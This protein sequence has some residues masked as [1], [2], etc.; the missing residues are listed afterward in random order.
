MRVLPLILGLIFIASCSQSTGQPSFLFRPAPKPGIA[1]KMG[2]TEISEAELMDGIETELYEAESK[3]FEVKYNRLRSLVMEKIMEKDPR[4]KGLTNDEYLE[5]YI[6]SKV[7]VSE[8]DVDA[9]V[10]K[11]NIPKE[12]INPM[13]REK[14]K[15]YLG[16]EKKKEAMDK[17]LAEQTAKNPVE[18]YLV[19]PRRPSFDVQVGNAPVTGGKDAKVTVIEFSDFQCPFCARGA[20]VIG[21]LKKKYGDKI[22]VA[23][24]NFP[25]PFH[26]QAEGAA[27]AGLCANEQGLFWKMHDE[28]FGHQDKLDLDSLKKTAAKLGAK[29]DQFAQCLD[30]K[31]TLDQVKADM[32]EGKKFKVKS[33]PTFFVNGQV[34]N[35]AQPLEVFTDLIDEALA[36]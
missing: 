23:F 4:K 11:Q 8:Q 12:H 29:A 15:N 31:K 27:I 34:I 1:A 16:M 26:N 5:K 32:E 22:K 3:V 20:E 14:I 28:M 17:W 36:N 7:V 33:T 9:F 6:A 19:K 30:G 25:L 10:K 2:N 13:V 18:V 35:G 24:K 21:E